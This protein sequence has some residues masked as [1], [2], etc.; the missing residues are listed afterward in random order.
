MKKKIFCR[1]FSLVELLIVMTIIA[2]LTGA[3]ALG[4]MSNTTVDAFAETSRIEEGIRSLRSA[5][6]ASWAES[7]YKELSAP[8][9]KTTYTS[10]SDEIVKHLSRY[11]DRALEDDIERCGGFVVAAH[12]GGLYLGYADVMRKIA[13]DGSGVR[14]AIARN[15][16]RSS[17]DLRSGTFARYSSGGEVLIRVR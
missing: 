12:D 8:A 17:L 15:L 5:W 10:G 14:E 7:Y 4:G 9:A 6:I 3:I 11:S 13:D 16:A 1:G 2:V